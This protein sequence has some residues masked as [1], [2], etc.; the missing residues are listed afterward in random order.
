MRPN[1]HF[2]QL[3][4]KSNLMK[5]QLINTAIIITLAT[6]PIIHA[7]QATTD[8]QEVLSEQQA[9]Y[10]QPTVIGFGSGVIA[11]AIIAG[12][13]GAAVAGTIGLLIGN[14]EETDTKH[15]KTKVSLASTQQA[16]SAATSK[17]QA[18]NHKLLA[19]KKENNTLNQQLILANNTLEI[20]ENIEKLKLNLQFDVNS[21]ELESFYQEQVT[22]LATLI[23]NSPNL[24]IHLSGHADRN[25]ESSD[26]L[27]LSQ[28]RVSTVKAMLIEHG[29]NENNIMTQ[30]LGENAPIVTQQ[31]LQNDFYDRRVE[32]KIIQ[33]DVEQVAESVISDSTL[34]AGN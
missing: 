22:H 34:T 1:K 25:G 3:T 11:G 30:A 9:I 28:K 6:S 12:P 13:I 24:Q 32:L 31:S 4:K 26:N 14:A 15:Q 33:P 19:A 29:I 2:H 27:I 18:L 23:Q 8:T 17:E 7:K 21:S 10:K 16:L 20:A 5:K